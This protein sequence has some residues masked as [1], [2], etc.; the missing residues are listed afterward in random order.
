MRRYGLNYHNKGPFLPV[1][2]L[3]KIGQGDRSPHIMG[4]VPGQK[5]V[6]KIDGPKN[7]VKDQVKNGMIV[8]PADHHG[9]YTQ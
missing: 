8:V 5:F 4:Q 3:F 9:I 6:N 2:N 7:P 1:F